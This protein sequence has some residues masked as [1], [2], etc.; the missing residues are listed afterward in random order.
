MLNQLLK[1]IVCLTVALLCCISVC[2]KEE[3]I[4]TAF[5]NS[6]VDRNV[7]DFIS[8]QP[9][10]SLISVTEDLLVGDIAYI[11]LGMENV[12]NPYAFEGEIAYDASK[13][14]F[15]QVEF[16]DG[17]ISKTE[18]ADETITFVYS[19][20][21]E[22]EISDVDKLAVFQFTCLTEQ[23]STVTLTSAATVNTQL[24]LKRDSA[25]SLTAS[26]KMK[27]SDPPKRPSSGGGGS[28]GGGSIRPQTVP[29]Q[30]TPTEPLP[31]PEPEPDEVIEP[32]IAPTFRDLQGF[33]WAEE[34]IISLSAKNIL[35]GTG[36]GNFEPFRPMT[37]AEAAKV[38]ISAFPPE[39]DERDVRFFSD[40]EEGAWYTECIRSASAQGWISGYENGSFEPNQQIT[41][42]DFAVILMRIA[43]VK[44]LSS[45]QT[46]RSFTDFA[47]VSDYAA[48][49]VN[50][51]AA[52]GIVHGDENGAFAPQSPMTRA[53]AAQILYSILTAIEEG[54]IE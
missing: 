1:R 25:L 13:L 52:R 51:L 5:K 10:W 28:F 8:P 34:A 42:E 45:E 14:R 7:N 24:L 30:V 31:T 53:E 43:Q 17:G 26:V 54:S 40:V 47:L 11:T 48:S 50:E 22:T 2:A 6:D 21:G 20:V 37:R 12:E 38:L 32:V 3:N 41:R 39:S 23:D 44:M 35:L 27:K 4:S 15:E 49:A 33:E 18:I 16:P 9:T 19:C 46:E 36:G 29:S